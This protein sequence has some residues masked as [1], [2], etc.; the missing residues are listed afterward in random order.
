MNSQA[1]IMHCPPVGDALADMPPFL[2]ADQAV[3]VPLEATYTAA[4]VE[5]P[6]RWRRVLEA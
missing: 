5:M 1:R 4:F 2:E 3:T 6:L